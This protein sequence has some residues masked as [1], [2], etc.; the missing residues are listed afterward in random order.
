MNKLEIL[1]DNFVFSYSTNVLS[2]LGNFKK[3]KS[4]AKKEF[5]I[6]LEAI[7]TKPT[8]WGLDETTF[9]IVEKDFTFKN[10]NPSTSFDNSTITIKSNKCEVGEISEIE[11]GSFGIRLSVIKDDIMEDGNPNC[12]WTWVT[13]KYRGNSFDEVK[14]W[15]NEQKYSLMS[16]YNLK[17]R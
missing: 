2:S 6:E 10:N 16:K 4:R 14:T 17:L 12:D 15:L 3:M 5:G 8:E 7:D 11:R 1:K 9:R 13:L